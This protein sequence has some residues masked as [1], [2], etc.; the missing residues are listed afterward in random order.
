MATRVYIDQLQ[1]EVDL[2]Y[3]STSDRGFTVTTLDYPI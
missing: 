1:M 2:Y 3:R